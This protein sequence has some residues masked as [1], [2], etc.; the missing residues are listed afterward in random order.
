M[1][2]P[3]PDIDFRE[4]HAHPRTLKQES[5]HWSRRNGVFTIHFNCDPDDLV[6]SEAEVNAADIKFKC[7]GG[8]NAIL[9]GN[10][11]AV[12]GETHLQSASIPKRGG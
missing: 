2:L 12:L 11:F 10:E 3:M 6:F 1:Q 9:N 4:T 8:E 7:S 5:A